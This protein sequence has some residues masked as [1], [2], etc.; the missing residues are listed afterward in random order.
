MEQIIKKALAGGYSEQNIWYDIGKKVSDTKFESV[1]NM[2][3]RQLCA[4]VVTDPLF[5]Q[6]LGRACG[7]EISQDCFYC[8]DCEN[9]EKSNWFFRKHCRECGKM[10]IQFT[11]TTKKMVE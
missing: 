11:Y 3:T 7:W 1:I 6:A 10:Q 9:K 5:W 2:R 4:E 8:P